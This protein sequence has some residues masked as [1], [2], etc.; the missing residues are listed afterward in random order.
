MHLGCAY[1]RHYLPSNPICLFV[2]GVTKGP[3]GKHQW[4]VSVSELLSNNF[5]VVS[6]LVTLRDLLQI[7]DK[8]LS[9]SRCI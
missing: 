3:V 2:L 6:E 9:C 7:T 4:D 1:H 8:R 5:L